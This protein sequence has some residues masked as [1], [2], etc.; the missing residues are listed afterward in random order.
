MDWTQDFCLSCDRQTSNGAYC[1]QSCRLTD[2]EQAGSGSPTVLMATAPVSRTFSPSTYSS[3]GLNAA[4]GFYLPPP[5]D[6]AACRSSSGNPK[7]TRSTRTAPTSPTTYTSAFKLQT[8]SQGQYPSTKASAA[9]P[10][11]YPR[12]RSPIFSSLLESSNGKMNC[13]DGN[14]SERH[15]TP[16]SSGISLSSMRSVS[17]CQSLSDQARAQLQI[18]HSSFDSTRDLKRRATMG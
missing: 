8:S 16:S 6:F 7:T 1:S 11:A 15:L 17:S 4:S 5:I 18:Y 12:V 13:F 9:Y 3:D 10:S 2:I 14:V